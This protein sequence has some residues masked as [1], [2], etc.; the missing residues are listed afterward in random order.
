METT[1]FRF[2]GEICR[3]HVKDVGAE[4]AHCFMKRPVDVFDRSRNDSVLTFGKCR[5]KALRG[6][7]S[8]LSI[9]RWN[10]QKIDA[11]HVN[12]FPL[13]NVFAT[14]LEIIP[15]ANIRFYVYVA[16]CFCYFDASSPSVGLSVCLHVC[17]SV[18]CP[19]L[20]SLAVCLRCRYTLHQHT[21]IM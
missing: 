5:C 16:I 13:E 11:F 6:V 3:T 7:S 9:T 12:T 20:V 21:V 1:Q 8:L 14:L 15:C 18:C 4:A 19:V 10:H 2:V 17:L